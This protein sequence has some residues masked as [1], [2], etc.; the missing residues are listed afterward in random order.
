[1]RLIKKQTIQ[2]RILSVILSGGLVAIA[3]FL[4]FWTVVEIQRENDALV[5]SVSINTDRVSNRL[6]SI[7]SEQFNTA[8][9]I[10]HA[11][12]LRRYII[13]IGQ[14]N[15]KK[16][17]PVIKQE[18]RAI[19]SR[20]QDVTPAS[21]EARE[22]LEPLEAQFLRDIVAASSGI[23]DSIEIT[24][25]FGRIRLASR[26]PDRVIAADEN[27]WRNA[28]IINPEEVF[29]GDMTYRETLHLW[30][31]SIP[32][33]NDEGID[34]VGIIRLRLRMEALCQRALDANRLQDVSAH[35]LNGRIMYPLP[36]IPYVLDADTITRIQSLKTGIIMNRNKNLLLAFSSV[37]NPSDTDLSK[38]DWIVVL[39]KQPKGVLSWHNPEMQNALLLSLA[40][41]LILILISLVLSRWITEPLL[42]LTQAVREISE[43]KLDVRIPATG[44]GEIATLASLFND[45]V[46]RLSTTNK[47][48]NYLLKQLTESL[49]TISEFVKEVSPVKD[50]RAIAEIFL[51][52][53]IRHVD[54]DAGFVVLSEPE[55]PED[56][57]RIPA[58]S[59]RMNQ[60]VIQSLINFPTP[61]PTGT[62][63]YYAWTHDELKAIWSAGYQVLSIIPIHTMDSVMGS[64][65]LLFRQAPEEALEKASLLEVLSLKAGIHIAHNRL[66]SI[67]VREKLR[68]EGILSGITASITTIDKNMT[69]TWHSPHAHTFLN[70]PPDTRLCGRHCYTILRNRDKICPDCPV[71]Q[72]FET[73][74]P[75]RIIQRWL[76]PENEIRWVEASAF[77]L[78]NVQNEVAS[79]ILVNSDVTRQV[80]ENLA[81]NRFSHAIENIGEAVIILDING[82]IVYTNSSFNT[83]FKYC[84]SDIENESSQ[85]LF[86]T[87]SIPVF[88]TILTR[89]RRDKLWKGELEL[90]DRYRNRLTVSLTAS[91]VKDVSGFP[92]GIVLTCVDISEQ[93][94]QQRE[95]MRRYREL[96]I[97][98]KL[99][100]TVMEARDTQSLLREA[101]DTVIEASGAS[102]GVIVVFDPESGKPEIAGEHDLP[103][104]LS[105]F[106]EEIQHGRS[107]EG[108]KKL[109]STIKPVISPDLR[110][111][112][113]S[114]AKLLVRLGFTSM[115]SI[116]IMIS[117]RL[118]GLL[119]LLARQPFQF[120]EDDRATYS[121]IA[122]QL[123]ISV[124][125]SQLQDRLLQEAR[126]ISVGELLDR[127]GGD[128]KQVLQGL[129]NSRQRIDSALK[130]RDV[131]FLE[132]GWSA[133]NR[134]IWQLYQ[135][136]TNIWDYPK[137]FPQLFFPE[138]PNTICENCFKFITD[139]Q[140]SNRMNLRFTPSENLK[141]VFVNKLTLSKAVNNLLTLAVEAVWAV[142]EPQIHLVLNDTSETPDRYQIIICHNGP[143]VPE[144]DLR[145]IAGGDMSGECARGMGLTMALVK[146]MIDSHYGS[147]RVSACP[148][149]SDHR[150]FIIELPRY[151]GLK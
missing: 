88:N 65:F 75:Q 130:A 10:S 12:S 147:F 98:T 107:S 82:K 113:Q 9:M 6:K 67:L 15:L 76:S 136:L 148:R 124:Q 36:K 151:P 72:A 97:L 134:Q 74:E 57:T 128:V 132:E 84:K 35:I 39:L 52:F 41:V 99:A 8:I 149:E 19:E 127:I 117:D 105:K 5:D 102:A 145:I 121:A 7:V 103:V 25:V 29:S 61:P 93:K 120:R 142:D 47:K 87:E 80:N 79:V 108:L 43:G 26:L 94:H 23:I 111:N 22:I 109:R 68:I 86:P 33:R 100:Q 123:G 50:N 83:I 73:N 146:R 115:V 28:L 54:A 114:E 110:P 17:L 119:I 53:C 14:N 89:T 122:A 42:I 21:P 34:A 143:S 20:W 70:L 66:N 30:D 46:R 135:V 44:H 32:L 90:Q 133:I 60:T 131:A 137:E 4:S 16:P 112:S 58:A 144:K 150:A 141:E 38:P 81:V 139:Q 2:S 56:T 55:D 69:I 48:V 78:R 140:F 129:E 31:L 96:E 24:D 13:A 138:N 95:F 27:W 101:L 125:N 1:M 104:Y 91:A 37:F 40:G 51:R 18:M 71:Q 64:V 45:M 106:I 85:I 3:V 63:L 126:L 77:P 59:W 49:N 116:R 11:L 118:F 92:S 62:N